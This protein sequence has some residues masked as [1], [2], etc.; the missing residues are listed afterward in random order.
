MPLLQT[1]E[2]VKAFGGVRAVDGVSIDVD[3]RTITL[4]IGPNGSGKSTLINLITGFLNADSG[5]VIF[6]GKDITNKD[7]NEIY[8]YGIVRTF[9]TPQLMKNM[10]V[11][12]NLLIANVHPGERPFSA[13]RRGFWIKTEEELA[14]RAFS[15]LKF[16]KLDHLW[17]RP[18]G[19]MSGGQMKLLEIG[20]ALMTEPKMIVMDEPVAGVAPSLAHDILGKLV[21]LRERGITVLLIEHRLDIVLGYVDHLYVMFNGKILTEGRGKEGIGRVVND[22]RVA[23]IYMGG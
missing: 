17:D 13:L 18:A 2:L 23:E 16:L 14:E 21:E 8:H 19:T 7:P 4:I 20:R 6:A 1:R 22:P 5:R 10:S 9:Q 12:E 15:I 11:V 3:E